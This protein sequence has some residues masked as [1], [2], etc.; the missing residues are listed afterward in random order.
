[1][2]S[3]SV[4]IPYKD[5]IKYFFLTLRSILNQTYKNFS[6][7]II[8]DDEN[9]QDLTKIRKFIYQKDIKTKIKIILNRKN[10]GAGKS[11]NIGI[12]YSKSKYIA[13]LDSDDV[14][15]KNKLKTQLNFMR[16]FKI[17]FSHTSYNIINEFEF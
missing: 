15:H 13:F 1:M 6:I 5:N 17:P 11:R 7:V 8:Y 12:K 16:R 4:I 9:R 10:I 2:S 14:W 3:V